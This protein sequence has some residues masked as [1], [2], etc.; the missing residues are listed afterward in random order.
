[1]RCAVGGPSMLQFNIINARNGNDDDARPEKNETERWHGMT[2]TVGRSRME[3]A[4]IQKQTVPLNEQLERLLVFRKTC[5][6]FSKQFY[7]R[8]RIISHHVNVSLLTST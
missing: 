1:M 5:N 7:K 4:S 6:C 3:Q 2:G 8:K